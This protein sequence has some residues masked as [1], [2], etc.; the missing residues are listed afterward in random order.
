MANHQQVGRMCSHAVLH[1]DALLIVAVVAALFAQALHDAHKSYMMRAND[2][3]IDGMSVSS[4]P[5]Q[6]APDAFL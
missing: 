5:L 2:F 1:F 3:T 6:L 4:W